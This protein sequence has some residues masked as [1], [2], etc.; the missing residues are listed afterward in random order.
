MRLHITLFVIVA[1]LIQA[2][3]R[4]GG[5]PPG[6]LDRDTYLS[7]YCDLLQ[8]SLRGRN[9]GADPRTA[10]ANAE[11]VLTKRG[12]TRAEFDSTTHWFNADVG[13]WKGFFDDAARELERRELQPHQPTR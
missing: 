7:V 9:A 3:C 12:V 6:T 1:C 10:K 8:E 13:R 4:S 5:N 2:G 11:A